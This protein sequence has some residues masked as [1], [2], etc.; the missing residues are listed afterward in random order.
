MKYSILYLAGLLLIT[1][2]AIAESSGN[3]NQLSVM[4][5]DEITVKGKVVD[6]NG[7]PLPGATVQEKGTVKGGITDA[8]GDFSIIVSSNATLVFSFIGFR[9]AEVNVN[10]RSDIGVTTLLSEMQELTQIV[11]V[12]YGSQ[13]KV[14]LTGSVAIVNTEEMKKVSHSNIS[15]M[16][17]GKV[18]GVQITS[19]G[20]PGADPV[21]R[22]RG[23]G[24]FGSTDPLY[25]IDGIPVGTSIRDFSPNDI[26]SVQVL[27]DASAAAIYGSR[28]A[29]GVVII[30][31]KQGSKQQPM[32]IDY[33]GYVGFDKVKDGVYDVMDSY[34][35]SDYIR[36]AFANSEMTP[37]QGY[38][39]GSPRYIDPAA[40]NTNWQD[41]AFQTGVRQNHNVNIS[42]GSEKSTYNA[43][44]DYFKQEGTIYGAGP[45]FERYTARLNN[46]ME[47]RFLKIQTNVS[48]SRSDQDNMALSNANEYVQ[49]LY[50]AQY[51]VMASALILPPTIKAYDESTWVLDDILPAAS[52]YSYDSYGYGTYY[53]DV[54]G[55]LRVTNVLLIN[56]LLKRNVKV[57]R[58]MI[59]GA[60]MVDLLEMT[61]FDSDNHSFNYKLNLSY[62]KTFAKDFTFI[63][64]F[65]QSTTNYL[66][67]GDEVLSQGYRNYKTSL[68]ENILTYD[69][70]FGRSKLNIVA[71]QSFESNIYHT[72]TGRGIK[73]NEPYYP[74]INNAEETDA[75][76]Y[77]S[78]HTLASYV[79][80]INYNFAD[81]YLLSATVRRDGSSRFPKDGRWGTF[82]SISLG[83][84][85][86]QEDFFPVEQEIISL[87][88]LRGSYGELGKQDIGDYLFMDVMA[89]NNYTYSFGNSKITGSAISNF[90]N[91]G[92][93]WEKK[94]TTNIGLDLG[95]FGRQIEFS[96]EWYKS[97]SEDL[98]YEVP[99]PASGGFTNETVVMNAAT[100]ENTGLEFNLIY[101]NRKNPLKFE[102]EANLST[103][104]NEVTQ[105][106][107]SNTPYTTAFTRTEVGREVGSFYG[108]VYE[109]IFQSKEEID[110]RR[111]A[112][113]DFI[114]QPGAKP[115]DVAYADL[116]NDGE[117]TSEDRTYLGSGMPSFNF[118]FNARL[119]WKNFD[120][121]IATYGAADFKVL[122]F[123]DMTLHSSY[124]MLNKSVD[125]MNAW[126]P[127]NTDTNIP[128]VAYKS[129]G[130]ITNDMFSERFL[131]NGTYLKVANI[132]LGY[133]LPDSWFRGKISGVRVYATGQNLIT[134]TN[135]TG[136][137]IDFAGGVH[138]PGYNYSSYP[139]PQTVMFGLNF[140]F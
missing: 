42:G 48:Y 34:Q 28:A 73:L 45:N 112:N 117:I 35:Y 57:D 113:G 40:V 93:T 85:I 61:G 138:T 21:V 120:L 20:Q 137:N 38:D 3:A 88:K 99:V 51:P 135:Y 16:L 9:E 95:L 62:N 59:S 14:D 66:S 127:D 69:G 11:V 91:T 67:K 86:D 71:V 103:L 79:G 17:T 74:Q 125:M 19:D 63:P 2:A 15:T 41:E 64:S 58:F 55:D 109:G 77:E 111:N 121:S 5:A 39:P 92:I 76:S 104:N 13:R 43:A 50:G 27:K 78:E 116:N 131:Q 10:G 29:N 89:R 49:G 54:H 80:R 82:P 83:W 114:N 102:L 46:T 84:R 30:T 140:S 129:E 139:T 134:F 130:A 90:V 68:I 124:G 108:Y 110:N 47:A 22:I 1:P 101:R 96:A 52:Q 24:S 6:E 106:G 56:S 23:V 18:P 87:L 132:T 94:K 37:P 65:I 75:G 72:L 26:E 8:N 70:A 12:G 25:V 4:Q 36:M 60:A 128:R 119:E 98:L 133:N 126:T 100:M 97:V 115:G 44:L 136:Y 105:L 32:K 118:G 33:S 31:T 122:D 7:E 107:V 53:D 123:V 81:R